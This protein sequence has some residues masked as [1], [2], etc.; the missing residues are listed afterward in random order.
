MICLAEASEQCCIVPR[1]EKIKI[2]MGLIRFVEIMRM[3][4]MAGGP[5]YSFLKLYRALIF[6]TLY[7]SINISPLHTKTTLNIVFDELLWVYEI[8]TLEA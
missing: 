7:E 6:F 4:V 8:T 1:L 2:I 3:G 5:S